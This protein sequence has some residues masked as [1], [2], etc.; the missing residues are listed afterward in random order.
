M[1]IFSVK[2]PKV[3]VIYIC[4]FTMTAEVYKYYMKILELVEVEDPSKRFHLVVPENYNK[5]H[6]HMSLSQ[7]MTY[8]PKAI[9]Q[10]ANLINDRQAYI[11][12][13]KTSSYD[14]KLSIQLGV[15]ILCGEP[16]ITNTFASKSGAKRIFQKCDIPIPVSAYDIYDE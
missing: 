10:I 5:F 1:R 14:I 13:G 2:D 15:P 12:P 8:S 7:A 4:P 11:V 3:D 9:K 16:Q 6:D